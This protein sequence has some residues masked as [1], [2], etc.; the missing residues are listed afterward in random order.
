MVDGKN[1]KQ[2]Q[3]NA[4]NVNNESNG[5]RSIIEE[6][7]N[8]LKSTLNTLENAKEKEKA[9]GEEL[10]AIEQRKESIAIPNT[11]EHDKT[12]KVKARKN[13]E[14]EELEEN[15]ILPSRLRSDSGNVYSSSVIVDSAKNKQGDL[16][17]IFEQID[18]EDMG[19]C[20]EDTCCRNTS[21]LVSM[22]KKLQK[23][24]DG[25]RKENQSQNNV[26]AQIGSDMRKIEDRLDENDKCIESLKKELDDYK[27][28]MKLIA[29][30]VVRQDQQISNLTRR[31][32]DAQQR[33]MYPNVVISGIPEKPNENTIQEYN[34]FI[35]DQLEIQE[36]I[37]VHRAFRIGTGKA[38]PI[39]A[40]LRDPTTQKGK[41]YNKVG[42]LKDKRN[43]EGGRYFVSDH[44]PEEYNEQRRRVNDIVAENRKKP[45][46]S[47]LNM[48]VKKGRLLINEQPY[49]KAITA[50]S[51]ADIFK[52]DEKLWDLANEIDM[53]KGEEES[54]LKSKFIAYAAAI[55]DH[56][57]IQAAY[58]KVR[59]KFANASHVACAYRLPGQNTP[60]LQDYVDDGEFGAGRV[61]LGVLKERLLMNIVVFMIH[62]HGGTNLG[63]I[64]F[65]LIKKVTQSA[66]SNLTKKL[67]Q[68]KREEEEQRLKDLAAQKNNPTPEE[69]IGWSDQENQQYST[70]TAK[71]D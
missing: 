58:T 45:T 66:V 61:M 4:I 40:E 14:L 47:K 57:D 39:I 25:I 3:N 29:N 22:I 32:N 5:D 63:P 56:D 12:C 60:N 55:Q 17:S 67:D 7:L 15:V 10:N 46:D 26:N 9:L 31:L 36:L 62:F 38:R 53:V 24:V 34:K 71:V 13:R 59:T 41:I 33:E 43:S 21:K 2:N 49:S 51:P 42:I 8:K 6:G 44:L 20:S 64:R 28:Q 70:K 18:E 48:T 27:F 65:D 23:S 35:Q 50:P 68:Q 54:K 69:W 1:I 30:V 16:G 37:P 11:D 52:P 19:P